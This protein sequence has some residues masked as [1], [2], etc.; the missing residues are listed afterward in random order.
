[1]KTFT[2]STNANKCPAQR[3]LSVVRRS[4]RAVPQ[5]KGRERLAVREG[6]RLV[7]RLPQAAPGS[8]PPVREIVVYRVDLRKASP[9]AGDRGSLSAPAEKGNLDRDYPY[10]VEN[11]SD[12][13]A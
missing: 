5:P 12:Y 2:A 9:V 1:M 3:V 6:D 4:I 13:C 8:R 10:W 7:L 11:G